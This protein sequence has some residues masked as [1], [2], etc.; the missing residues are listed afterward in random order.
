MMTFLKKPRHIFLIIL[1]VGGAAVLYQAFRDK[2]PEYETVAVETRTVTQEVRVTGR[3]KATDQ[4]DLAFE[5][6]GKVAG[7][8]AA[9]GAMVTNGQA[10]VSLDT[11]AIDAELNQARAGVVSAEAA[12]AQIEASRQREQA[13]LDQLKKGTRPEELLIAE[14]K[15]SNAIQ[16]KIDAEHSFVDGKQ[17]AETDLVNVY[18]TVRN[19]VSD[20]YTKADDAINQEIDALF[21]ADTTNPQ[22]TFATTNATLAAEVQNGRLSAAQALKILQASI[23]TSGTDAA[24]LDTLL[25]A[26]TAKLEI[27]RNFMSRLQDILPVAS[28]V[29]QT[30]ITT[31]RT[32]INTGRTALNVAL[33]AITTVQQAI[34]SQKLTNQSV[35]TTAQTAVNDAVQGWT[36]ATRELALSRAGATAEDVAAQAAQVSAAIA[37]IAAERAKILQAEATVVNLNVQWARLHIYSPLSGIVTSQEAKVGEIVAANVP[38]VSVLASSTFAVEANVAEADIVKVQVGGPATVTLDAYGDGQVFTATVTRID[39]AETIVDGVPTYTVTLHFTEANDAIKS[40]MTANVTMI[41][42]K[43]ENVL[44]IPQRAVQTVDGEKKVQLLRANNHVESV[45]VTVG[46]RGSDGYFEIISGV[47]ATDRVIISAAKN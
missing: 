38:I 37:N 9:V 2:Q 39:P 26:S 36:I 46:I 47:T 4:V 33:T 18:G 35:L 16:A 40:G 41:A 32:N 30:T 24:S 11:R 20:V 21:D 43:R 5:Q 28:G 34:V 29:P 15:V 12:L 27:L 44:A 14:T 25:L 1:I 13:K 7:V 19:T 10:L 23:A 3:V 42:M 45:P 6:G 22:L 17:K 31:Y 8:E